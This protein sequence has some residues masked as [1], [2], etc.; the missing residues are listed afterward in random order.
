MAYNS[1]SMKSQEPKKLAAKSSKKAADARKR[2]KKK[3]GKQP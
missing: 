2:G 3:P 1:K